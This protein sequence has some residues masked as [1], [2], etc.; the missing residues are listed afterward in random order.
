[1]ETN[2]RRETVRGKNRQKRKTGESSDVPERE[3]ERLNERCRKPMKNNFHRWG[4]GRASIAGEPFC[5]GESPMSSLCTGFE[6]RGMR[7]RVTERFRGLNGD[8]HGLPSQE[9]DQG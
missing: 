1:M 6:R 8:Q 7:L 3:V 9:L 4:G 5:P 2:W